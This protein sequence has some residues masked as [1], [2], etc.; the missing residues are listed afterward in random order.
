MVNAMK[1]LIISG[2]IIR[3]IWRVA[4]RRTITRALRKIVTAEIDRSTAIQ[5]VFDC[6][7]LSAGEFQVNPNDPAA[8]TVVAMVLMVIALCACL[9][10]GV[11]ATRIDPAQT[12]KAE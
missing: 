5:F 7:F 12:L 2:Y 1:S 10:P 4:K 9:A 6:N 11:R 8:H 3:K